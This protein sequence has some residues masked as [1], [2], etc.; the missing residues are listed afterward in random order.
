M[1]FKINVP[2][3][4]GAPRV[5][6]PFRLVTAA[7]IA[8]LLFSGNSA[9]SMLPSKV[10]APNP[11]LMVAHRGE[12]H[13]APENTL[14]AFNLAWARGVPAIEFDCFLTTDKRIIVIHDGNAKRTGGADLVIGET[15]SQ[16]LRKLDVGRWKGEAFTGEKMPFIEEVLATIP[17]HGIAYCEVKCG[18]EILPLL[19]EAIDRSGKRSRITIIS[20]KLDVC[21]GAKKLMPDLPVFLL[22]APDKDP[23]SGASL[24][25]DDSLI[26]TCL[27]H[28]LD[29][30]DLQYEKITRAL[31]GK[32]HAA[33]LKLI[34]WTCD[35]VDVARR[36]VADRVDGITTNRAAWL[37]GQLGLK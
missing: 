21:A 12:S 13:L 14:A 35:D 20:F 29:G 7:A 10:K 18:P 17:E 5:S 28:H 23:K 11:V 27:S 24:P 3:A 19:R 22:K 31:V 9:W 36:L 1:H 15:S 30:L 8:F 37:A 32:S 6:L 33:G 2:P 4:A 16:E 26:Q 25:Y 34:A